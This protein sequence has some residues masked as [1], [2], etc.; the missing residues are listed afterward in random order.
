LNS[1]HGQQVKTCV[2]RVVPGGLRSWN[3]TMDECRLAPNWLTATTYTEYVFTGW[4]PSNVYGLRTSYVVN[5]SPMWLSG[6]AAQWLS[7]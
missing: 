4:R 5:T 7:G 1:A 3:E 2:E 6:R